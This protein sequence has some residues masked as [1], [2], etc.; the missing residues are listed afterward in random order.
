MVLKKKNVFLLNNP[1][2]SQHEDSA[3]RQQDET[4]QGDDALEQHLKLLGI[5]FAAQVVHKGMNLTQAKHTKGRHVLRGLHRLVHEGR[6]TGG[7]LC[8]PR[9]EIRSAL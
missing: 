4:H 6:E 7:E 1:L 5:E 9:E 2:T 8:V 3:H